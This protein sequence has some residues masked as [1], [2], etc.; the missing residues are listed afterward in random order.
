M[1]DAQHVDGARCSPAAAAAAP[2]GRI[3]VEPG[4][5]A[6][7]SAAAAARPLRSSLKER[8]QASSA[9]AAASRSGVVVSPTAEA[10]CCAG[11]VTSPAGV[12]WDA[13][14]AVTDSGRVLG[15]PEELKNV[16]I[17]SQP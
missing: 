10:E 6:A 11:G 9:A 1:S 4:R 3:S 2:L 15:T 13:R 8:A 16:A 14:M 17:I 7:A 5:A 12:Q